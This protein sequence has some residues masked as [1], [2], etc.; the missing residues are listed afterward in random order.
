M[1]PR[2]S[3]SASLQFQGTLSVR[4]SFPLKKAQLERQLAI[5]ERRAGSSC[6]S[7]S[8]RGVRVKGSV[9]DDSR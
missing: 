8:E 5:R 1:H 3:S 6:R 7:S 4:V 2:Q 9:G